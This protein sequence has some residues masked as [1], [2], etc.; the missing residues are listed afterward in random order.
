MTFYRRSP[1]GCAGATSDRA[2]QGNVA[3]GRLQAAHPTGRTHQI[4]D[5]QAARHRFS[6]EHLLT[7]FGEK[8]VL[9]MLDSSSATLG[10][11]ALDYKPGQK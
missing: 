2:S 4:A 11:D 6:R 7:L 10:I 5:F 9:R 8:I 1:A 3:A